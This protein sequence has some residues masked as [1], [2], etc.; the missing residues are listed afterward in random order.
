MVVV[1]GGLESVGV[2]VAE[3]S[4][5]LGDVFGGEVV[6]GAD[7]ARA[8]QGFER[9]K[10]RAA[11]GF[12]EWASLDFVVGE[13]EEGLGWELAGLGGGEGVV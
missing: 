1:E 3:E 11:S 10:V 8:A 12:A 6:E 2:F 9:Y 7:G 5:E 4:V 13:V